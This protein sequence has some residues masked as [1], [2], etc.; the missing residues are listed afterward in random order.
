MSL[1]PRHRGRRRKD[2]LPSTHPLR[3]LFLDPVGG[4]P[5]AAARS[6]MSIG[7][8]VWIG[9]DGVV[10]RDGRPY[11]IA[12]GNP[13][14]ASHHR[15]APDIVGRPPAPSLWEWPGERIRDLETAFY[16]PVDAFLERGG[17]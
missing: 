7:S 12:A 1:T 4:N 15:F 13:A 10:T 8:G 16:G 11:A 17:G 9:A 5:V 2:R 6:D 14:R 3:T